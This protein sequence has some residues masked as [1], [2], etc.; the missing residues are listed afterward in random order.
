VGLRPI[1]LA[2]LAGISTQQVRNY[3]AAGIL[4]PAG[5]SPS[6]YRQFDEG[7]S[8]ALVTYRALAKGFG[9]QV[10]ADVMRAVY[11][12]DVP[13][14]LTLIDAAHAMV[15][16]QRLSLR[17]IGEALEAAAAGTVELPGVPAAGLRIGEAAKYLGV[18]PS[19]LRVWESAGLL[20]PARD[21]GTKYRLFDAE[22]LRYAQMV[23]MLRQGRYPL[24]QIKTILD[25]LRQA[26][27]SY[28]L[29]AAI[30]R[31]QEVLIQLSR[32]MLAGSAALQQHLV[33]RQERF[34][35]FLD[36]PDDGWPHREGAQI[37]P[38]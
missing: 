19:A 8:R 11:A 2:R 3:L 16:E 17:S 5:R 4:P 27:S 33:P 25:G 36:G 24:E 7:H 22:D 12:G 37:R 13:E 26:G 14:A 1:D 10:A 29:R 20:S 30:A 31:R 35:T 18:R 6:G 23:H 21:R 15:H 34:G 38:V 9:G 28:A 32:A